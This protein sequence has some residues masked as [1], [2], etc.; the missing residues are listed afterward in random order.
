[1]DRLSSPMTGGD[2]FDDERRP[3]RRVTRREDPRPRR[4]QRVGIDGNSLLA[5]DADAGT[6]RDEGQTSPLPNGEDDH[7]TGDDVLRTWLRLQC[8]PPCLIE[9]HKGNV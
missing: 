5:G 2:R 4:R 9:L 6:L 7:I 8:Q 1:M 3:G